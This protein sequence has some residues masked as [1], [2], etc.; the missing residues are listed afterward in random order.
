M[1]KKYFPFYTLLLV[2]FL[3]IWA[4]KSYINGVLY[5]YELL[6]YIGLVYCFSRVFILTKPHK[7]WFFWVAFL[8][9]LVLLISVFEVLLYDFTGQGFTNEVMFHFEWE[10]FRIGFDK[11]Y[12]PFLIAIFFVFGFFLAIFKLTPNF[13]IH[14][15]NLL[16]L[17][18][19]IPLLFYLPTSSLLRMVN[20]YYN[21]LFMKTTL[22]YHFL[23]QLEGQ[24]IINSVK[25]PKKGQLVVSS[26][27]EN[28]KNLILI[29]LESFNDFIMDD[30]RYV[31]LTPNL[32]KLA[33]QWKRHKKHLSSSYV[34]VEGIISS[35]CGTLLP[36]FKGNDS[37]MGNTGMMSELICM[38]DVLS[39]A[40]YQQYYLGGANLDM[41]G[42]GDFLAAHGYDSRWGIT[43]W[44][45]A[46][47]DFEPN[48]WGL[49]DSRLF[50]QAVK[51]IEQ[52]ANHSP[53]NLTLLTLGTHLPG[54]F[55]KDC[56]PYSH[57]DEP[58]IQA[59]H[60]T[61]QLIGQFIKTLE[62][63][64]LLDNTVVMITADHGVFPN[65]DM[66]RLFGEKVN[67]RRLITITNAENM[68]DRRFSSYDLAP[69][70]LDM[71]NVQHN[72]EFLYGISMHD[73]KQ[74]YLV[75]RYADWEGE[76][77][78]PNDKLHCQGPQVTELSWPLDSCE[79]RYLLRQTNLL[80]KEYSNL[81]ENTIL[82]CELN[83]KISLQD[84]FVIQLNENNYYDK[85]SMSGNPVN[86]ISQSKQGAFLMTMS[87]KL[88]EDFMYFI[89]DNKQLSRLGNYLSS[90]SEHD[91]AWLIL[92]V[93]PELRQ[94]S[95]L[96]YGDQTEYKQIFLELGPQN[97]VISV[98]GF[99]EKIEKV[100]NLCR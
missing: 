19:L 77:M 80:L 11:Y 21:P 83:V 12:L 13:K 26:G 2:P 36:M 47:L 42:K 20:S 1:N 6:V 28:H 70:I 95:W 78:S 75:T 91:K 9:A 69:S 71:L 31:D 33:G 32:T 34:T 40:G 67:D 38:G 22:D 93:P 99:N 56:K 82:G 18:V 27:V 43:E 41:A 65:P 35:Q 57:S 100:I 7:F 58:F 44:R 59:I 86:R 14:I 25:V 98:T 37:F 30:E 85:F 10:S 23:K 54:Y 79:K 4:F 5:V 84:P 50:E 72:A 81:S 15:S 8:Y 73:K 92:N 66:R 87:D 48:I 53:F 3:T 17:L 29:Y 45:E 90:I 55:Y 60:C 96:D 46:N 94:M 39:K 64:K 61:D 74:R 68:P 24:G 89:P 88:L 97:Q 62:E 63:K 16:F 76:A 49:P 52:A 51:I